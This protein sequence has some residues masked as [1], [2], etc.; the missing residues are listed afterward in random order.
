[1]ASLNQIENLLDWLTQEY[2]HIKDVLFIIKFTFTSKP[3]VIT[4]SSMTSNKMCNNNFVGLKK[5]IN[6]IK[7]GLIATF[8]KSVFVDE[9]LKLRKIVNYIEIDDI[10][11]KEEYIIK[12]LYNITTKLK[13]IIKLDPT[14]TL[15]HYSKNTE[16][17]Y[18]DIHMDRIHTY[19]GSFRNYEKIK[20]ERFIGFIN[21][22][23]N[24]CTNVEYYMTRFCNYYKIIFDEFKKYLNKIKVNNTIY[25]INNE[26]TKYINN[27]VISIVI[28]YLNKNNEFATK[29]EKQ[30]QNSKLMIKIENDEMYLCKDIVDHYNDKISLLES[31]DIWNFNYMYNKLISKTVYNYKTFG[32]MFMQSNN[33]YDFKTENMKVINV[34]YDIL[35]A[36]GFYYGGMG[37]AFNQTEYREID[38]IYIHKKLEK[39]IVEFYSI[40]RNNITES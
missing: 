5:I 12:L 25:C 7:I 38:L 30:K 13:S 29:K 22:Y 31:L 26:I 21:F 36:S 27:D 4:Y 37:N 16:P 39:A 34:I 2:E 9:I 20:D 17:L 15:L 18:P 40:V 6:N 1:M 14:K 33:I 19:A 32:Y 11:K 10:I 24:C 28:Q 3:F 8:G 35:I 23:K